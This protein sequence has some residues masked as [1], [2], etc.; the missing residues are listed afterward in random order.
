MINV[1][2]IIALG[3][4]PTIGLREGIEATYQWYKAH[5]A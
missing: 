5:V 4:E 2:K 1:D 3:W